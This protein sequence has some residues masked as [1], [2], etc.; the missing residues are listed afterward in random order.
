MLAV[1]H[2][3][4]EWEPELMSASPDTPVQVLSDHKALEYFM[5]KQRLTRRQLRWSEFI[6]GFN[7]KLTYRPRKL[8]IKPDALSRRLADF[9]RDAD[10]DQELSRHQ[11]DWITWL[12]IAELV[13]N[14]RDIEELG[15]SPI[16]A[17]CGRNAA[18]T[19][20]T[21]SH[22]DKAKAEAP[23]V[24]L[25]KQDAQEFV[26]NMRQLHN[27]LNQE[28]ELIHASRTEKPAAEAPAFRVGDLVW[29]DSR[30]LKNLIRPA[31]KLDDKRY[32]PYNVLR[33]IGD[34]NPRA[35][36]IN[37]PKSWN[38]S[39]RVFHVSLLSP[40]A[41]DPFPNQTPSAPPPVTMSETDEKS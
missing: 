19:V 38:L 5:T 39:T 37:V 16:M 11:D 25:A 6:S 40:V 7:W 26:Q 30:H 35:Y 31:K 29:L 24:R 33:P 34:K 27:N 2:A 17:D 1:I 20:S 3:F 41:T 23:P 9:P 32:G 8:A 12:P 28:L 36:E 4:E 10:D 21:V 15:M 22:G 13:L 18:F 14:N